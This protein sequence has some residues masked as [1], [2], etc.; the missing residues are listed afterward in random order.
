MRFIL[1]IIMTIVT[2]HNVTATEDLHNYI[3]TTYG[4]NEA[5]TQAYMALGHD[6][7]STIPEETFINNHFDSKF[8]ID[9]VAHRRAFFTV[10]LANEDHL[11]DSIIEI[12]K[13]MIVNEEDIKGLIKERRVLL[14]T[15]SKFLAVLDP[16]SSK[17]RQIMEWRNDK[18]IPITNEVYDIF[19]SE[20]VSAVGAMQ[21][22][23]RKFKKGLLL[24]ESPLIPNFSFE[25][26]G[27]SSNVLNPNAHKSVNSLF[28]SIINDS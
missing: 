8:H 10:Q 17:S 19:L 12:L 14:R 27:G 22:S 1:T 28:R 16:E 6:D 15:L 26:T 25:N 2:L 20:L 18:V 11:D 9:Q 5:L 24:N 7:D 13:P 4:N 3:T 23:M 21:S